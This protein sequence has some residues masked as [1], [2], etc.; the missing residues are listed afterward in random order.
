MSR[1]RMHSASQTGPSRPSDLGGSP[2]SPGLINLHRRRRSSF[3]QE[4]PTPRALESGGDV[5]PRL[6]GQS[7]RALESAHVEPEP[8]GYFSPSM[9]DPSSSSLPLMSLP[10]AVTPAP[11][12]AKSLRHADDGM[13]HDNVSLLHIESPS[14]APPF[15]PS[16]RPG[17]LR[18]ALSDYDP[19]SRPTPPGLHRSIS[20]TA[21]LDKSPKRDSAVAEIQSPRSPGPDVGTDSFRAKKSP[22]RSPRS[23]PAMTPVTRSPTMEGIGT[24]IDND[25][26][27]DESGTPTSMTAST[28]ISTP[29][30]WPGIIES[31]M[32]VGD[33]GLVDE[34]DMLPDMD[35]QM[36]VTFDDEGLN[37]L[38]RIFL[39][40]KSEYPFHRAYI[41]RVLGDLLKDVD[42]CE[43][44][45]YVLPLLSGFS[46]DDDES[47]KE[48][49]AA[50]LHRIL[51]YFYSTCRLVEEDTEAI[52]G[53]EYEPKRE[54]MVITSEGLQVVLKPSAAEVI[55][56]TD[57]TSQR[58]ASILSTA[59]PS[60][61]G[62]SLTHPSS[63]TFSPAAEEDDTPN[64]TVSDVPSS[65]GTAFSPGAFINPYADDTGSEKGWAKDIGPL[66]DRPTLAINFFTPLLGSLLLNENPGISDSVRLG[67]VHLIGRLRRKGQLDLEIWGRN[68]NGPE[69][70]ERRTFASQN[71]PH[72][73]DLRPFTAQ[74][75][76]KVEMELLQGIIVGMGK[77]ATDMP[78]ALF[79][80][81]Q[82]G[83][84]DS[85][86]Q[87]DEYRGEGGGLGDVSMSS[88]AEAFRFQLIQEATA[89]RAT[90]VNLI[91]AICEFY[92]GDE[93]A[94]RG[95]VD[96]VLRA[97]DGDVPVRAEA[98]VALSAM[99]K[100]VPV[101]RVYEL[102][103]FP[104]DRTVY[105]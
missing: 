73:H 53:M 4:F 48:A 29:A 54:T 100:I 5:R 82:V 90:S 16:A 41:A 101:E 92:N 31:E 6:A 85:L 2:Q 12:P 33:V 32:P 87:Y 88:E 105:W 18:R 34:G 75:R 60:S 26:E 68:A 80:E 56:A 52:G 10:P 47:V 91:G 89:G 1:N 9:R 86:Y 74:S 64:S 63:S 20:I 21:D 93:A 11:A 72:S 99:A 78:D 84:Q 15:V 97:R 70:D 43:S 59:G 95:F 42:P 23:L 103:S 36:D 96:E 19:K 22:K 27:M 94:E 14:A 24:C 71:G 77:L 3:S 37:T 40:S 44:V 83:D 66:V 45:E 17:V 25:E 39:L 28:H 69:P 102:V 98:A 8:G 104:E 81:T 79:S 55:A 30:T 61:A 67:V 38:E 57:T 7:P 35:F 51:W 58:R 50:E 49:F 76:A 65:Q 13:Y 62:S 46:V